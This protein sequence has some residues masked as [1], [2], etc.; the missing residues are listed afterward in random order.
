MRNT[1]ENAPPF[2]KPVKLSCEVE[3]AVTEIQNPIGHSQLSAISAMII[4]Q[5]LE[6]PTSILE[7][8]D[9]LARGRKEE[10]ITT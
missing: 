4:S 10:A 3:K 8:K 7:H 2:L 1:E 6:V 9:T 5:G